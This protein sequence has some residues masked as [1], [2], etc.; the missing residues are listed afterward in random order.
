M[1]CGLAH[2][3]SSA[4][5]GCPAESPAEHAKVALQRPAWEEN[6]EREIQRDEE[7]AFRKDRGMI[8]S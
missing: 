5:S 8:G 7:R 1:T 6:K 4:G 2:T 3:G